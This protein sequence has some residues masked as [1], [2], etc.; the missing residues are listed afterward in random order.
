MRTTICAIPGDGIG[1]EVVPAAVA[2]LRA[3]VPD[4]EVAWA[5]AGYETWSRTG[6]ALPAH[7]Q[8]LATSAAA[9]LFGAVSSPLQPTPGY[10]SAILLLRRRLD[11]YACVRPVR[12]LTPG[13]SPAMEGGEIGHRRAVSPPRHD[14]R[15][16]PAVDPRAEQRGRRAALAAGEGSPVDLIVVRENTEGLYGG[17]EE[18]D[19]ERAVARR[20]VT[21]VASLRIARL[22]FDTARRLGRKRV[23]IVHK[24]TVL[25][26]TCGLFRA[27]AF[28][29]ARG[30]PE[31][32]VDEM[33]VDNAALRLA[34]HPEDID[35]VVTTN[36]FGDILSDVASMHGGGLGLA[37]SANIGDRAAVFEPVHGSAPDIAGRGIANP[38]AAILAGAMLLD[39]I[40]ARDAARAVRSAV[41]ATI[42]SPVRTPDLGGAA[43]TQEVT[44]AVIAALTH[45]LTW[46][47]SLPPH[48]EGLT[49]VDFL[50]GGAPG[51]AAHTSTQEVTRRATPSDPPSRVTNLPLKGGEGRMAAPSLSPLSGAG[52]A[53]PNAGPRVESAGYLR[54]A[55]P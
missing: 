28:E 25:P 4:L 22:A 48:G 6:E 8:H 34:A 41:A 9:T 17:G 10:Q 1:R 37:P 23:T 30:Y 19:G 40:G 20:V 2:V 15:A 52:R 38:L 50:C 51:D 21:R 39:H 31:I 27:T 5:E 12:S 35:I 16:G 49:R 26:Q 53:G 11:L 7:A 36:L 24:A 13:P 32:A 44:R 45:P 33:L 54:E 42:A 46:R 3:A 18:S 43:T 29:V 14:E 47:P 55:C